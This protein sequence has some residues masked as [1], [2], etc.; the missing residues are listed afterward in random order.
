MFDLLVKLTLKGLTEKNEKNFSFETV[1]KKDVLDLIWEV[2]GNKATVSYDILV[3]V[4]KE[5]V[6]A[7][8]EKLPD[9]F[10][11]NCVRSGTFPEIL[12]KAEVT[13]V[14][15]KGDPTSKTDYRPVN[16]LSSFSKMFGKLIYLQL[17]N[18][19]QS[20]FSVY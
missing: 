1:F 8:Y 18:Y 7:Y 4:L 12:K 13:P 2:P 17:N 15:K 3:S 11:I 6:S 16:T 5:S 19:M 20:K 14:F 10:E 9:I